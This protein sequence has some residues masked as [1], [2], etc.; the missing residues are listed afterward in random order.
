MVRN[1]SR[2]RTSFTRTFA[3]SL[4]SI[5]AMSRCCTRLPMSA[6]TFASCALRSARSLSA[7]TRTGPSNLR[8]RSTRPARWYSAPNAVLRKPSTISPSV[9]LFFSARWREAI[10]GNSPATAMVAVSGT[11]ATVASASR[12]MRKP[13]EGGANALIARRRCRIRNRRTRPHIHACRGFLLVVQHDHGGADSDAAIEVADVLVGHA[14]A[15]RGYRLADRLRL[16]GAVDAVERR[17]QIHRA[18]AERILDAALHVT[19]QVRPARQ[20]L[21]RRRPVRPFL[22]GGDPVHA[23]PAEA[24]AADTDAVAQGLTVLEHQ[25]E[26]ALRGVHHDRAGGV[27]AVVHDGG[28]GNRARA[29]AEEIR[30]AAH[31]VAG[32]EL[33]GEG[34]AGGRRQQCDGG[35]RR[36]K[37]PDHCS[38]SKKI[39]STEVTGHICELSASHGTVREASL[40]NGVT[41]SATMPICRK[42]L[43]KRAHRRAAMPAIALTRRANND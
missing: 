22:L 39:D 31:D 14:E 36:G 13:D 40:M 26:P 41:K 20:H 25:I 12:A 42:A 43:A 38:P 24:V 29:A 5:M 8:M 6:T 3:A 7:K 35:N 27:I 11:S 28:A 23:A 4:E 30:A 10:A 15:A 1:R 37:N 21:R 16:V 33:L 9:K 32:V 34:A 17:A 18:R 19:R 2:S